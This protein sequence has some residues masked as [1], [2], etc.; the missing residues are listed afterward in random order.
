M[1]RPRPESLSSLSFGGGILGKFLFDGFEAILSF[2]GDGA[3]ALP[4]ILL[5][6]RPTSTIYY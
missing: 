4:R 6:L 1:S 2:A 5:P 3:V